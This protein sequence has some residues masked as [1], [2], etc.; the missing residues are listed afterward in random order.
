MVETGL[1]IREFQ[2]GDET[3]FR[4][5][6]EEWIARYFV[7]EEKDKA[8]L[9]DPW[10]TILNRGG[11]IF[12]ALREGQPVGC[13]ALLAMGPGEFEV[14]K[15][16]ITESCQGMGLG[17]RLLDRAILDARAAGGKRLY[18]ETNE[19]LTPAIRL[20]ESAGFRHLP[21]ERIVPSPYARANVYMELWLDEKATAV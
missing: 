16:A 6:N 5:L 4:T 15:M 18:L 12:L 11:R 17:R 3:A 7:L 14:A 2:S 20:Y 10:G 21:P 1:T 8:S 19:I 9:A 13:C